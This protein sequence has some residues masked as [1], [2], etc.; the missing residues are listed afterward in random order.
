MVPSNQAD[1]YRAL[2]FGNKA[3]PILS[4][5]LIYSLLE[6]RQRRIWLIDR[7]AVAIGTEMR[8]DLGDWIKRRLRRGVQEQGKLAQDQIEE[9]GIEVKELER[10][11]VSQKE[12]QLSI[13]SCKSSNKVLC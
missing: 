13:R 7:Q 12:S 4:C 6:Q 1:W 5:Q 10:Q 9:C 2:F 11:W 3:R 8:T